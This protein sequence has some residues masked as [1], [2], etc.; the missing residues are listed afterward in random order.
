MITPALASLS[1]A[2]AAGPAL[3]RPVT[4]REAELLTVTMDLLRETGYDLLTIDEV[5]ARAH[6]SKATIY[7]RWPSKDELVCAAFTHH[8][9]IGATP[10]TGSLR[11]D[12]LQFARILAQ[13]AARYGST[14]AGIISSQRRSPRL[15]EVFLD[16]YRRARRDQTLT[17]L[18]RAAA[19]GEIDAAVISEQLWDL[20]PCYISQKMTLH[21]HPVS[22]ELLTALVDQVLM[23]SLTRLTPSAARPCHH[24]RCGEG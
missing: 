7:R 23:P 8:V 12:L 6:A 19:R 17:I 22:S 14:I 9:H 11:E 1:P 21:G 3:A 5:A 15:R 20:L 18:H 13:N 24:H 10:D 2:G 4:A 16:E